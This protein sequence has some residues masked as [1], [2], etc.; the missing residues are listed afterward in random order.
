MGFVLIRSGSYSGRN[1]YNQVS[2]RPDGVVY[3]GV[4]FSSKFPADTA[5]YEVYIDE[6]DRLIAVKFLSKSTENSNPVRHLGNTSLYAC[7]AAALR[8]FG[9]NDFI[10][11]IR[12]DANKSKDMVIFSA[13]D[14]IK[15]I[16]KGGEK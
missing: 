7:C 14:L 3:I 16:K 9:I 8:S 5:H 2:V 11:T 12:V 13:D 6:T 4:S 10:G 1:L 15:E